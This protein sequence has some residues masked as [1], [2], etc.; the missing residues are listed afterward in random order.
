MMD[1][2]SL[3]SLAP[4]VISA[5]LRGRHPA[6]AYARRYQPLRLVYDSS[7]LSGF[8]L[9]GASFIGS[10]KERVCGAETRGLGCER[11]ALLLRSLQILERHS[12]QH[13]RLHRYGPTADY[14]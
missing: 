1:R 2:I 8:Q 13:S 3:A 7:M 5:P 6:T 14:T 11:E 4:V 9:L 10:A 12:K